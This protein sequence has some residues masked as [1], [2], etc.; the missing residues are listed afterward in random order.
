MIAPN[1]YGTTNPPSTQN[2]YDALNRLFTTADRAGGNTT[3]AYD[4]NDHLTQVKTP[5]GATTGYVVDD[6]GNVLSESSPDRGVTTYTYDGAGNLTSKTDARGI[7]TN[8]TYDALNRLTS[9]TYPSDTTE[10]VTYTYDSSPGCTNGV[11]RLCSVT[12]E[13]GTTNY[14][15]DG[16][17]HVISTARLEANVTYTTAYD[18]DALGRVLDE[19]YPDGRVVSYTRDALGRIKNVT[20][21]VNGSPVTLVSQ[22]KWRADNLLSAQTWGNGLAETRSYDYAGR[23]TTQTI[24]TDTRVYGYDN[25][26]NLTSLQTVP[27]V[28]CYGYDLVDRIIQGTVLTQSGAACPA[29]TPGSVYKYDGNGNRLSKTTGTPTVT[30]NFTAY[31]NRLASIGGNAVTTNLIGGI[32]VDTQGYTFAYDNAGRRFAVYQ[33]GGILADYSYDSE[34]RRT[35]KFSAEGIIHYH[36]DTQGHLIEETFQDG[37]FHRAYIWADDTPIAQITKDSSGQE[38]ITYLHTDYDNTPRLATDSTGKIVWRWDSAFGDAAPNPNLMT[39]NLRYPGQYFDQET[40]LVYNRARYYD[41]GTGRFVSADP[42]SVQEHVASAFA[43]LRSG[44]MTGQSPLELNP[45]AYTADNPLRWTDP[46]GQGVANAIEWCASNPEACAGA[47]TGSLGAALGAGIG[48]MLYSPTL[49]EGED[50]HIRHCQALK[51]SVLATCASLTGRKKFACF[52]AAQAS[53]DQCM[54]E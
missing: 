29:A 27:A 15:Y 42:V 41:P 11:G 1:Q 45:Y 7:V 44:A 19:T 3:Y 33:S 48:A 8:Y 22:M 36:Y 50:E 6:L 34:N 23:L 47:G 46:T 10:N 24:G 30:Y 9:V 49:C 17:G 51:D 54:E 39:V 31:S 13:S 26:G 32:R 20:A 25:N 5:N 37:T 16:F 40:G 28:D 38:V 53:Y 2:Q 43:D 4:A 21:T 52:A 35:I 14:A 12:D 18:P